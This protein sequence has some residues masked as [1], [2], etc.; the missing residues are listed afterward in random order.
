MTLGVVAV[1]LGQQ[2]P[3]AW[4]GAAPMAPGTLDPA[5]QRSM[6]VPVSATSQPKL[7]PPD[8]DTGRA[9][10]IGS[11]SPNEG[12]RRGELG[13]WMGESGGPGV[14][15]LRITADSAA[16][17]A[18]LRVGDVILQVNGQGASSPHE[19]A[20]LIRQIGIGQTGNLT[21][22]RDGNQQQVQFSLKP[23]REAA[24]AM[25]VEPSHEAAFSGSDARDSDLASRTERLEQQIN[26]LTQ[27]LASLRQEITQLRTN[28]PVQ[29][30]YN[31]QATQSAP[32]PQPEERYSEAQKV[33][34]PPTPPPNQPPSA[35]APAEATPA[36][37]TH[38]PATPATP[39]A[40]P[41]EKSSSNDLFGAD[42]AQPKSQEKPK[43]EEKPK[44]D[45]KN[46]S[47]DLFK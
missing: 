19:T 30:G 17:Q 45:N 28:G 4:Q 10:N 12:Q 38:P 9:M 2:Q 40:P 34:V 29:T 16:A 36:K 32:P 23:A 25:M 27:Q 22:W 21:I 37:P 14:Q 6:L 31:V 43:T 44:A 33:A 8:V 35:T 39:P 3:G 26:S 1:A 7:P 11:S 18:G 46:G 42:S 41:A 20:N 15:I 47:D 24:R 13:I 5:G